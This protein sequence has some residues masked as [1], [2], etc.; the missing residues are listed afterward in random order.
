MCVGGA[1]LIQQLL[2]CPVLFSFLYQFSFVNKIN[3]NYFTLRSTCDHCHQNIKLYD[4]IPIFS[5]IMLKGTSRCCKKKLSYCYVLGEIL[6][7]LPAFYFYFIPPFNH[8]E[9]PT[10]LLIYLFLLVFALFDITTYTIPLHMLAVL[11]FTSIYITHLNIFPFIIVT[12]ILHTLF[13]INRKSIGYGDI[14]LLS[15]LSL[16]LPFNLFKLTFL[17]TFLLGGVFALFTLFVT[18]NLKYKLPFIPFIF[19]AYNIAFFIYQ[20][21]GGYFI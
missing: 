16:I 1:T 3:F 11:L 2:F 7:I 5:F 8:F 19:I 13:L 10:F 17:L 14:L 9:N 18:R 20:Y 4:M 6:A 12:I 21:T 15:L